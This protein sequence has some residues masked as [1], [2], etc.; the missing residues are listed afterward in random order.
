[1][2]IKEY[3]DFVEKGTKLNYGNANQIGTMI[4]KYWV[5]KKRMWLTEQHKKIKKVL[6]IGQNKD[7]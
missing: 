1:M 4:F 2:S 5:Q 6:K 3:L 7:R